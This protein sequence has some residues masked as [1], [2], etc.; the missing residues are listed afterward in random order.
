MPAPTFN[1]IG[2]IVTDMARSLAFYRVLGLDPPPGADT[3]PH[4]EVALPGGLRLA[5][6]TEGTIR[7]FDPDWTPSAGAGRLTL[8]FACDD[9][10]EVDARYAEL[11]TAGHRGH[12]PPWDAFWGQ[13][14][15]T[16]LDPDGNHVDLFAALAAAAD[17]PTPPAAVS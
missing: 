3:E 8:A 9:P 12:L 4:V 10:A 13:R 14:Y 15:A 7:S 17:V 1:L 16:V 6:D 2:L 11:L 5:F